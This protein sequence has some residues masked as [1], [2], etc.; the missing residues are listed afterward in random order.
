MYLGLALN[1]PKYDLLY[2]EKHRDSGFKYS[3]VKDKII[4]GIWNV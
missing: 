3:L 4:A 1:Y 2:F